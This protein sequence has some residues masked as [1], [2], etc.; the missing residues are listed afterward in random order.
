MT[1]EENLASLYNHE[2]KNHQFDHFNFND[3]NFVGL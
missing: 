1:G 2:K 3:I